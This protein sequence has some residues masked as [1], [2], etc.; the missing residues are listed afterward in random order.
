M[1]G[2][3]AFADVNHRWGMIGAA[4]RVGFAL[5]ALGD[6]D[7]AQERFRWAL[8]QAQA[9]EAISLALLTLSGDR[10]RCS[11]EKGRRVMRQSY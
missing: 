5:V 1:A 4:C 3:D 8:A 11:D 7:G 9:T 6:F 10:R 2:Y